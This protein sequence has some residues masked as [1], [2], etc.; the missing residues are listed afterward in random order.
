MLFNW[1]QGSRTGADVGG[2]AIVHVTQA[3]GVPQSYV[4]AVVDSQ[5][6]TSQDT[7][8]V[9]VV[10]KHPAEHLQRECGAGDLWPPNRKMVPATVTTSRGR[11]RR[12]RRR[13][14]S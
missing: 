13:A 8:A 9:T 3:L 14:R 7:T 5:G 2:D 12:A 1:R 10:D 6:Q 11:H 4:L